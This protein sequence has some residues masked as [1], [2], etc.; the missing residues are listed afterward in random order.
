MNINLKDVYVAHER[1]VDMRREAER[2]NSAVRMAAET[3]PARPH[4]GQRVG[5]PLEPGAPGVALEMRV[6]RATI[7]EIRSPRRGNDD[8]SYIADGIAPP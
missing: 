6:D 7:Q 3:C 2:H 8:E 1:Y 4:P 5:R